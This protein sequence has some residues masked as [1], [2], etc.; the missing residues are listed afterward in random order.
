MRVLLLTPPMT[1]L[2]TPYPATSH[3]TGFLRGEGHDA[4]QVDLALALALR[5]FSRSGIEAIAA[6]AADSPA[7]FTHASVAHLLEHREELA[8]VIDRVVAF[9]QGRDNAVAYRIVSGM[10]PE[11]PRFDTLDRFADEDPL[12]W[13]FGALGLTDRARH[14]ATLL[15]EDVADAVTAAVDPHFGLV[16]YAERLAHSQPRFDPLYNALTGEDGLLDAW[17]DALVEGALAEHD[18]ELVAITAPFA[19]NA[20]GALRIG[21]RAR[22]HLDGRGLVVLGGGWVNTDL[23]GLRDPRVFDF[24]DRV[25]LDA[26]ERP[27]LQ[28]LDGGPPVR[29]FRREGDTVVFESDPTC[30]DLAF[31][32]VGTP[33]LDG[34]DTGAYLG[35]LDTLNPMHRLWADTRWN[36]LTVA[37]GCYWKKCAFCDTSLDY[38]RRYDPADTGVLV[39]RMEALIDESGQSG[40][41]FTDEAAPPG[42]LRRL[43]EEI[44]RR[45]LTVT[46]WG[47]VRFEKA[48]TPDVA[49]LLA[50]SGCVALT[51]G[52]EVASDRL[53]ALMQKGVTVPQVAR[54]T[55]A[56]ADAGIL[57]HAYLMYGFPTQ[58]VQETV[59]ALEV[60]RQLFEAGC[61]HSAF[62]HR[63]ALTVHSP[64]ARDPDRYGII[65]EEPPPA[66]F[67]ANDLDFRDPTGADHAALGPALE[68]ALYNYLH[69]VGLDEDV[70]AWFDQDVPATTISPDHI[71]HAL[72]APGRD[73]V[74][75]SP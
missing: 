42:K 16:R 38:I 7:R 62:W 49:E 45:D 26:G 54:V 66:D 75:G 23:R 52:L 1:Q 20:Y 35:L 2:N 55:H 70:R 18:P 4:R 56:L 15:L 59:D 51:G 64:I 28:L 14:L 19:G 61:L 31:D 40:F 9:L 46:W 69:G 5:L 48:F 17:L 60:V 50:A 24:V 58:T 12:G 44:L 21:R 71:F 29:T 47:N 72:A 36:K 30:P 41:H 3:L 32:A 13:A 8:S 65:V 74:G 11:G 67:G 34:L 37:H 10:L 39:D 25:V 63:F 43:A 6:V 68:R 22:A 73:R 27:L 53:L 33:T 57:V